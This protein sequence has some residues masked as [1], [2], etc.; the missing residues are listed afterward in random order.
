VKRDELFL[1]LFL[2]LVTGWWFCPGL[3]GG[4]RHTLPRHRSRWMRIRLHLRM[5]PGPGFASAFELWLR[6]GRL[7]SF[8]ESGRSRPSL[9]IWARLTDAESHSVFLGRAQRWI[10]LRL[11][12]Q[13]HAA[14]IGP[15]RSFKSA[16]LSKV[17]IR[18]RGAAVSTSSKGDM[19]ALTSGVRSRR[20]PVYVFNPQG[21]GGIR[22]NIRW[23][24][25]EGCVNPGTAI[26]RAA[27]FASAIQTGNA[28]DGD[29]FAA[30]AGSH[31]RALFSAGALADSDMRQVARWALDSGID[32]PVG[33][34][35]EYG[36]ADWA[37]SLAQLE[38]PAERTNATVRMVLRECLAYMADPELAIATLP[39]PDG[40]FEIDDFLLSGGTLYMIAKSEKDSPMAPLFAALASEIQYRATQLGAQ[41][42]K[43]RLDPPLLMALD[44]V[45]QICPVPL[46]SWLADS[47][48]QGVQ[49]ISA[50]HGVAQLRERWGQSGAQVVMDTSGC[51]ILYPGIT[52][53]E[54]LRAFAN[55]TGTH[56]YRVRGGRDEGT[57]RHED[58]VTPEMIRRLPPRFV[59]LIRG[60]NAPVAAKL[61]LGW[62]DR[63]YKQEKRAGREV[64]ALPGSES[65]PLAEPDR[66]PVLDREPV[67]R[68]RPAGDREPAMSGDREMAD[69]LPAPVPDEAPSYPWSGGR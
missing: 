62:K 59:L 16:L 51:K 3:P 14:L 24:P 7:A 28:E 21:I 64:A 29:F 25:I 46:P 53:D 57:E 32:G 56:A 58:V 43:G 10:S 22:S 52:D 13:E 68:L 40:N 12:V 30:Q 6:W 48:G 41:M 44:E 5:K 45:T 15:P 17:I 63:E 47:G 66:L 39:G 4:R 67:A 26:R 65:L 55:L 31:L 19:F 36:F 2:A 27:A 42:P 61:A 34:L 37:K 50:F 60:G 33:I 35:A 54:T 9:S 49:V 18:H 69:V 20:G 23:N 8:R 1:F 38:G 11:P